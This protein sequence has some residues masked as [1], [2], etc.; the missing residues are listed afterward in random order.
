MSSILQ[1]GIPRRG[2]QLETSNINRLLY[3]YYKVVEIYSLKELTVYSDKLPAF[4]AIPQ[5]LHATFGGDYVAG[6][7]TPRYRPWLI[8]ACSDHNGF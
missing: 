8:M 5:G 1:S 4:S 3:D 2:S 6:L 7:W